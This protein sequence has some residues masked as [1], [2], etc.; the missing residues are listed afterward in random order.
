MLISGWILV[1][2]AIVVVVVLG[3][4]ALALRRALD[5]TRF[6]RGAYAHTSEQVHTLLEEA[7]EEVARTDGRG[8]AGRAIGDG[9][10][11]SMEAHN[12]ATAGAQVP[13]LLT[14]YAEVLDSVFRRTAAQ[15]IEWIGTADLEHFRTRS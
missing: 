13:S 12:G 9:E 15:D 4:L 2:A 3:S 8:A 11:D 6:W 1:L 14:R 5:E 10:G 7:C